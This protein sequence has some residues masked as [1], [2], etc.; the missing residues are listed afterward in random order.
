MN[1][2]KT[3]KKPTAKAKKK[4]NKKAA[5]VGQAIGGFTNNGMMIN[6]HHPGKGKK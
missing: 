5:A 2:G 1:Y 4:M 3:P 6:S